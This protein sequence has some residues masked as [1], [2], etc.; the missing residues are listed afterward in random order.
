MPTS[1]QSTHLI[2]ENG[3]PLGSLLESWQIDVDID[4]ADECD[5]KLNCIKGGG[6]CHLQEKIVAYNSKRFI[7]IADYTKRSKYLCDKYKKGK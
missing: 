7:V 5:A 6:G 4:G 2:T 1:Y 3:L